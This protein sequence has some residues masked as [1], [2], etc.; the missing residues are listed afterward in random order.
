MGT[1]PI[2]VCPHDTFTCHDGQTIDI[3]GL[4]RAEALAL[5]KDDPTGESEAQKVTR[6]EVYVI[7]CAVGVSE[8]EA[9]AWHT[10]SPSGDV[11]RLVDAIG[12][13]SGMHMATGKADAE[14][15][16]SAK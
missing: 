6:I 12:R 15:L 13:L 4:S 10:A 7:A 16:H 1:L 9:W 3:R 2:L 8:A 5:K 14:G 11:E